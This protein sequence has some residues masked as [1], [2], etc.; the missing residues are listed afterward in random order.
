MIRSA[1]LGRMGYGEALAVQEQMV[2]AKI[3]DRSVGDALLLLEHE[4][5]YT[6]GRTLD[7]RSLGGGKLPYPVVVTGR[8]GQAT[9]HGPGQLIG[10]PVIDLKEHGEDLHRYLRKLEGLI[11]AICGH[12][13]VV[14][15]RK[16]GLTGV[17]V[18]EKKI[19]SI[20]IGVRR[21]VSMHGFALNVGGDLSPYEAITPCGIAGVEMTSLERESGRALEVEAVAAIASGLVGQHLCRDVSLGGQKV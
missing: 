20:G 11:M 12:W 15:E 17:W 6:I 16:E 19:A 9:Y 5:V 7:Q 18:G 13:G 4:S 8:G 21:W 1:W 14:G 2:A 3:A 10:Y